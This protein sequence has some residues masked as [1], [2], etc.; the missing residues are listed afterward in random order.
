M[1]SGQHFLGPYQLV[2]MIRSGQT[3]QVWEAIKT[4][5]DQRAAL[6][7][8]LREHLA[9]KEQVEALRHEAHVGKQL[10]HPKIIHIYEFLQQHT[11]PFVAM[12][13]FNA[14]NLKQEVRDHFHRLLSDIDNTIMSCCEGLAFMHR[15]G[16]LH[17]DMKPD[18]Y[19]IND[20]REVKL[21]DFSIAQK[22]T[23]G[24]FFSGWGKSSKAVAGT[25][26]YMAPE[27][28]RGKHLTVATDIYGL[29]CMMFELVS[30]KLP[31]TAGTPNELLSKHLSAPI[32]SVLPANNMVTDAFA[33]MLTKMMAKSPSDR[34]ASVDAIV[35]DLKKTRILKPGSM[36]K[37][38]GSDK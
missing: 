33:N 27:Q 28:I 9:D 29:G 35:A 20:K 34:Y 7:V 16:W 5:T 15:K 11:L 4:G 30:G 1:A 22:I 37:I 2:R 38:V 23:K 18:N 24:G 25:R 13:L 8:L 17:C 3:C 19:L 21:I 26:S 31:Y 32:P 6:K 10:D 36:R 12:E 14:M